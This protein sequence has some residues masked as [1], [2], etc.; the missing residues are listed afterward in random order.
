MTDVPDAS[1][2]MPRRSPRIS[3]GGAPVSGAVAIVLAL[4]AVVAGFL[5]LSSISDG[6]DN[7]LDFPAGE[8]GSGN[9]GDQATTTLDPSATTAVPTLAPTTTTPAIVVEGASVLVANMNGVGGSAGAMM[10]ALQTGPGFTVVDAV[11]ASPSLSEQDAS[12]IY[13]DAAQTGAQAVA[14]SLA[15]VLGGVETVAPLTGTPPTEDGDLRGAGVLLMLGN[16]KAGKTLAELNPALVES[17]TQ[18][19]NPPIG[20]TSTTVAGG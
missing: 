13:Y 17:S 8:D 20:T 1:G 4:V 2:P 19:T 10:R 11:N 15:E 3:D 7:A 5:I 18:V 16:D 6:G 9:A 12:I 14:E